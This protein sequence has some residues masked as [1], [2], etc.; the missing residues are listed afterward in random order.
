MKAKNNRDLH[1]GSLLFCLCA[2]WR[3]DT[4]SIEKLQKLELGDDFVGIASDHE[5]LVGGNDDDFDRRF[6]A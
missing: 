2:S 5:F 3:L 4:I 1:A 6:I